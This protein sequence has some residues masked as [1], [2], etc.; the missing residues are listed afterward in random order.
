MQ[1]RMKQ[2]PY[3][4]VKADLQTELFRLKICFG[5]CDVIVTALVTINYYITERLCKAMVCV[6]NK[7]LFLVYRERW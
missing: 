2:M 7:N 1:H 6:A 5:P 3:Y 4:Q